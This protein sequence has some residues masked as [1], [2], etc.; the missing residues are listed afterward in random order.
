[1]DKVNF[2]LRDK[3]IVKNLSVFFPAYNEEKNIGPT[4]KKAVSVL[5]GL[6]LNS[7]EIIIVDD[8]SKDKTGEISDELAAESPCIRVIHQRNGGYGMALRTGFYSSKLDWI[9]YTDSDDQ[10][11]F[12]EITKVINKAEE[13]GLDLVVGYRI[14][15]Q[16]PILR[17]ING[18][19]W[20]TL[21]N[22]LFGLRIKD[23]DCAFKLVNKNVIETISPLESTRGGMISPE[24]LEKAKKA[25]FKIGQVGVK[26]FARKYGNP[27]GAK[28]SVIIKSF[29]DLFKLWLKSF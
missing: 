7:F 27:T 15:R 17:R 9:F 11:D 4:V 24:L 16:D 8:G 14:D 19:G 28:L 20:T 21:T 1:M 26:H 10:F 3:R 18:W 12:S 5:E 29:L 6:K 13:E 22:L 2:S 25:K 23:V